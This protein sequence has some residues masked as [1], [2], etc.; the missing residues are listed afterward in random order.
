MAVLDS[1]AD[2]F[3]VMLGSNDGKSGA[4]DPNAFVN[5]YIGFC[6]NMVS[7]PQKPKVYLAAPPPFYSQFAPPASV[8][9]LNATV[10]NE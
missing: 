8:D 2:V 1:N 7:L 3:V 5:D 6:K 10:I 4:W 9:G